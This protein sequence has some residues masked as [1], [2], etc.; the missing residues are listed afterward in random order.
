MLI[1]LILWRGGMTETTRYYTR[2]KKA[3]RN[4]LTETV[5]RIISELEQLESVS[6]IYAERMNKGLSASK[7]HTRIRITRVSPKDITIAVTD[8]VARQ[9]VRV[10]TSS[11]STVYN[12]LTALSK[13]HR[14]KF[15]E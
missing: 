14:I 6:Y 8:S 12:V 3:S 7:G 1:S 11:Y 2:T 4:Q 15:C 5:T 13:R 10:V 9:D